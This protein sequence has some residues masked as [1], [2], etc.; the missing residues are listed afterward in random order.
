MKEDKLK[1]KEDGQSALRAIEVGKVYDTHLSPFL[2]ARPEL[3]QKISHL[4]SMS[5]DIITNVGFQSC[6]ISSRVLMKSVKNDFLEERSRRM[7]RVSVKVQ[8][9]SRRASL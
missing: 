3:S 5:F 7:S 4:G 2:I 1:V 8:R 6:D 9:E